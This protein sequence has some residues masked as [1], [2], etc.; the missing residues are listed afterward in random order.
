MG[1]EEF[2]KNIQFE[3]GVELSFGQINGV[4]ILHFN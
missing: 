2:S 3:V 4:V 1:W